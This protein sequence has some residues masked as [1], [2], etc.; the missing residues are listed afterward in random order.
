MART[1]ISVLTEDPW[2]SDMVKHTFESA[3]FEVG[4]AGQDEK[5]LLNYIEKNTLADHILFVRPSA[6]YLF[7]HNELNLRS[8]CKIN[9]LLIG[10]PLQEDFKQLIHRSNIS[11]Y[12]TINSITVSNAPQIVADL[13]QK[14]YYANDQIPESIWLQNPKGTQKLAMPIFTAREQ[15]VLNLI[16]HGFTNNETAEVLNCS[17]S[18]IQNHINRIKSKALASTSVELVAISIANRWVH[19]TREKFK[20]HNPFIMNFTRP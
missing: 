5:I 6:R 11:G 3:H 12:L 17:V 10:L 13:A 15:Q 8:K 18:N 2:L 20:R 1:I 7:A 9:V 4:Y 16:C 14:G 19:L